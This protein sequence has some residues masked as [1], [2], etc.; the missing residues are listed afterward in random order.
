MIGGLIG[1]CIPLAACA[2]LAAFRG[3]TTAATMIARPSLEQLRVAV[4]LADQVG[5]AL[6]TSG[7][8]GV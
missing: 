2:I 3:Q 7:P 4:A 5:A 6:A 1:G 8:G